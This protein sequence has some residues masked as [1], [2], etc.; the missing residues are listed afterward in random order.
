V[1]KD[2][3]RRGVEDSEWTVGRQRFGVAMILGHDGKV[4]VSQ[5][6]I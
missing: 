3:Q 1:I 5:D 4:A 2:M 6:I